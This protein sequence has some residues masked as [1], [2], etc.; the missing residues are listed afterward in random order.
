[1]TNT[2]G[3]A[4]YSGRSLAQTLAFSL[5]ALCAIVL[6][7]SGGVRL[8]TH[9]RLKQQ[10][11]T[12]K[13]QLMANA[14]SEAV[15]G[16]INEKLSVLETAAW[17]TDPHGLSKTEQK[18]F[19]QKIAGLRSS[20]KQLLLFD[21][22]DNEIVRAS[23]RSRSVEN[24]RVIP[25]LR[26]VRA[27]VHTSH[28]YL[29]PVYID[30][31][32][33]EPTILIGLRVADAFGTVQGSLV[34]EVN[35]KFMWDLVG[36]LDLG[37]GGKAY[38]VD[39]T[40]ALIAFGDPSRVL[41][42]ESARYLKPVAEFVAD[43]GFHAT[44]ASMYTGIDGDV[45]VGVWVPLQQ[46]D[47]AV[48][49][50]VP[51]HDAYAETL[52][53]SV[54]NIALFVVLA[55]LAAFV[56]V[57]LARRLSDPLVRLMNTAGMIA[58]GERA[59]QAEVS[60]PREIVALAEAFN[61]MTGQLNTSVLDLEHQVEE[62]RRAERALR[63]KS[64]E[65][66]VYFTNALDLLCIADTDGKFRRLNREWESTLGFSV[67]ELEG[68]SFL[69]YVHPDDM[70]ST[71]QA[72]SRLGSQNEVLGFVNRYRCKDGSYRWI[73][74]RSLPVGNMVYAAARDITGRRQAE[75]SIRRLNEELER[76]VA[77]R[78]EQLETANKELEAFSYSVSH[79]LRAPLRAVDGFTRML[80]EDHSASLD[81]EGQRVCG[82]IR[83]ETQR[84]GSLIDDLLKFSRLGRASMS[85]A[86]IDMSALAT[87]AFHAVTAPDDRDRID[88]NLQE[89]PPVP[90]DLSMM[91]QVWVNLISNAVK[92][93][94]KISRAR[95]EV[96][97]R[98][99]DRECEYT[100][101]DNGAGFDRQYIARLF[102]VFQRLHS[103]KEFEGTGVGLAIVQ[104]IIHRHG[105]R[106]WA[107]S[108]PGKGAT[109]H[110]SLPRD[111]T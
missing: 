26:E 43:S 86:A 63:E 92:F 79:D 65:L 31:T 18:A 72:L 28:Q 29:S 94:S 36:N 88:W 77:D 51:W 47:W 37:G 15:R 59:L 8:A 74:W 40:G 105:G 49:V 2:P 58:R 69:D 101:C 14:A 54:I 3:T 83:Q 52:Q 99:D 60:G 102:G 46:P 84:M 16:F 45:V 13:Q 109:F 57:R 24:Q 56:G 103:S 68:Q 44:G 10:A 100:V 97:G 1:M 106:I 38:V 108:E 21:S 48:V 87:E 55:G 111:R 61:S 4:T 107:E 90:G 75:E 82:V 5:F 17:I 34:G 81:S 9:L 12:D 89:L 39:K 71:Q 53:E 96:S 42:G 35:L 19:L 78:T 50:E 104:R 95:I 33:S 66:D 110:F 70:G 85:V 11:I 30:S 73:E 22:L 20:F 7:I 93:S 64:A 41:K 91:R 62:V 76:R 32:T 6:L 27:A 80:V 67:S 23:R 98:Q 25:Y